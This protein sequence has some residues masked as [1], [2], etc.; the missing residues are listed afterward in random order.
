MIEGRSR[1]RPYK[2]S[3]GFWV[4]VK[5]VSRGATH[6]ARPDV[7]CR[8]SRP[9]VSRRLLWCISRVV[10]GIDEAQHGPLER[11]LVGSHGEILAEFMQEVQAFLCMEGG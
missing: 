3:V 2:G 10:G 9:E 5:S 8:F 11:A 6:C 4:D 7:G 1:L